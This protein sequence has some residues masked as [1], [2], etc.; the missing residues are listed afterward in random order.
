MVQSLFAWHSE[1]FINNPDTI[2]DNNIYRQHL[3]PVAPHN[4]YSETIIFQPNYSQLKIGLK[5][6]LSEPLLPEETQR[7]LCVIAVLISYSLWYGENDEMATIMSLA[8]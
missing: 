5:N 4:I 3:Y 7:L 8:Y 2:A 6:H 1:H